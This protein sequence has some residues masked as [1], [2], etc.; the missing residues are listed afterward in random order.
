MD[1]PRLLNAD[2]G[3]QLGSGQTSS[4]PSLEQ[5]PSPVPTLQTSYASS[6]DSVDWSEPS[7]NAVDWNE[8][9]L[10]SAF[11][12]RDSGKDPGTP[13]LALTVRGSLPHNALS[14]ASKNTGKDTLGC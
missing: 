4:T 8:L 13:S 11:E 5:S 6:L 10:S 9:M 14:L 7:P 3:S 1:V 2:P 12:D